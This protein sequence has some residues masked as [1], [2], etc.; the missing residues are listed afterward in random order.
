[1]PQYQAP[2]NVSGIGFSSGRSLAA[3]DG[4]VTAPDDLTEFEAKE[5]A[6]S[7]FTLITDGANASAPSAPAIAVA[8]PKPAT[9]TTPTP[10][11]AATPDAGTA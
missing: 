6:D 9:P 7:G 4:V 8:R 10:P 1:M 11:A 5:L 3:T 2:T